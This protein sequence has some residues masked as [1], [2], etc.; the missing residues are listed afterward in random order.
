MYY[1]DKYIKYK[2]KYIGLK[3]NLNN[4]SLIGGGSLEINEFNT[5]QKKT[6]SSE[7]TSYELN[8]SIDNSQA[9]TSFVSTPFVSTPDSKIK[10]KITSMN[11]D[12]EKKNNN[13]FIYFTSESVFEP[14]LLKSTSLSNSANLTNS[15]SSANLTNSSSSANLTNSSSSASSANLSNSASLS[16]KFDFSPIIKTKSGR[17]IY[18][19]TWLSDCITKITPMLLRHVKQNDKE[20]MDRFIADI[21]IDKLEIERVQNIQ[22]K[23][24]P[25]HINY[26][27]FGKPIECWIADNMLCPCCGE[28]TLRRYSKDNFA[29]I[30]LIC[31]NPAH[32]F[33]IGVKFF[34]VKTTLK[35]KPILINGLEYFDFKKQIIH[36]GSRKI[37]E[38]AHTISVTQSL[39]EKKILIGYICIYYNEVESSSNITLNLKESFVVLPNINQNFPGRQLTYKKV[40]NTHIK[41]PEEEKEEILYYWYLE[42][43]DKID[44]VI[45]E[46]H[47]VI[48]FSKKLNTIRNLVGLL[49]SN[50]VPKNYCDDRTKWVEIPNPNNLLQINFYPKKNI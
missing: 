37:G 35:N 19:P 17:E 21:Q 13:L 23:H 44:Q 36:T 27:N 5:P 24:D 39:F 22:D 18:P 6:K 20:S 2:I 30:D 43:T 42:K 28:K 32:T 26:M 9:S 34:Q 4:K 46:K 45:D 3:K 11:E 47:P 7:D 49:S 8:P 10:R 40:I 15:S 48:K 38:P 16:G 31:I 33:N 1:Y 25:V 50:K 41:T 12:Y 29:V 14:D